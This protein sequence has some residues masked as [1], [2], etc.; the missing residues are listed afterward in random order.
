MSEKLPTKDEN[1]SEWFAT[2]L[3]TAEI[4]DFR[5]PVKGMGIWLPHGFAIR[6]N[7][8]RIVRELHDETGH[9]EVLFPLL[10]PESFFRKESEHIA[11]FESQ[12][13]WVTQ[14]G[15]SPLDVKLL[16]RPTSETAIYPMFKL[17]IRSHADLP[18]KVYQIVS[19]FRYET[20]ATKPLIRVREITTFKE[21]HTAHATIEDLMKELDTAV[22]VYSSIFDRLLLPYLVSKRPDWDKFAG[23]E[24][25]MAFDTLTPD[26]RTL[27]IGTVHNLGRNFAHAF[28]IQFETEIGSHEYVYQS[29]FGISERVIA[30]LIS[31]HGDDRGLVLPP[32]VA[33]VQVVIVPIYY[34]KKEEKV[35]EVAD[36]VLSR[37][38]SAGLRVYLDNRDELTPGAKY[39]YHEL[40]G[41]PVRLEIGPRDVEKNQVTVVR[42]DTLEKKQISIDTVIEHIRTLM[43][44]ITKNMKVKA[45]QKFK[46]RIFTANNLEEI[47]TILNSR[48]GIVEISWCGEEGCAQEIE[49]E[50]QGSILGTPVIETEIAVS[51]CTICQKPGKVVVRIARAY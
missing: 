35:R 47:K 27:Q 42:R 43:D 8:L 20:K 22:W 9:Q 32:E 33:P 5:Y 28:D 17:W 15:L 50:I 26:G 3:S 44:E 49:E 4:T 29:C 18:V 7:V 48:S 45:E 21:A 12:V 10:I 14:G 36:Q 13:Y 2:I 34:K 51:D 41:V 38:S 30:A 6:K 37:L 40:R 24:Y 16:L 31:V 39:Y 23:A 25:S 11:G 1:F 19:I 46:E